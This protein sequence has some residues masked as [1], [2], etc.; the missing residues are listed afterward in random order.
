MKKILIPFLILAAFAGACS[1]DKTDVP[2]P[3]DPNQ[4]TFKV[5]V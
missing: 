4:L 5:S 3:T 2:P 1:D